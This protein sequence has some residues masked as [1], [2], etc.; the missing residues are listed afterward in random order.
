[1]AAPDP[2]VLSMDPDLLSAL[3]TLPPRQRAALWLRY[4]DDLATADVA[5][6]LRC[7]DT[8]AKQLLLRARDSLRER[9]T[10]QEMK[11]RYRP[12]KSKAACERSLRRPRCVPPTNR[13]SRRFTCLR[14]RARAAAPRTGR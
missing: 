1:R 3:R 13:P 11:K 7:S 5:R 4:C 14:A 6:I 8:A 2:I 12:K 10:Q 9:L